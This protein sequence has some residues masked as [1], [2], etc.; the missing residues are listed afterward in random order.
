MVV[1]PHCGPQ[2]RGSVQGDKSH[3]ISLAE[4][5]TNTQPAVSQQGEAPALTRLAGERGIFYK[6]AGGHLR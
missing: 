3:G 2:A 5:R 1:M 6:T 4:P